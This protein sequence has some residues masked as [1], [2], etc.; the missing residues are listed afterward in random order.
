M[1]ARVV[2]DSPLPHL[3]RLFDYDVPAELIDEVALGCRVKVRFAGRLVDAFV[4][5]LVEV[6]EHQGTLAPLAKVVSS[7]RVIAPAVAELCRAVADRWAGSADQQMRG[8]PPPA[9]A[10]RNSGPPGHGSHTLW[11]AGRRSAAAVVAGAG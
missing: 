5:D 3:D 10:E 6:S 7:E 1:I 2:V 8:V 11:S 4:L 9:R